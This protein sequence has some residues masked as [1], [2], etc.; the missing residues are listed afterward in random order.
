MY[1]FQSFK[2]P[3]EPR[4]WFE[5]ITL[6][7]PLR[8]RPRLQMFSFHIALLAILGESMFDSMSRFSS[9]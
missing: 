5:K 6:C 2:A 3:N 7:G 4:F 8:C 9:S 1:P